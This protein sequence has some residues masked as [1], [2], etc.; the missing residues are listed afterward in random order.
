MSRTS[1]T[2][3]LPRLLAALCCFVV[4][5]Y[6]ALVALDA[7]IYRLLPR[8]RLF[9]PKQR[10]LLYSYGVFDPATNPLY[11]PWLHG[12]VNK[13][14]LPPLPGT[15][16]DAYRAYGMYLP[17]PPT[18]TVSA[19]DALGWWNTRMPRDA[20]VLF[21]G[22]SFCYGA[23]SGSA[24]SIPALYEKATGRP[25]YA[26]CKNG[27]GLPQYRDILR[28][29]TEEVPADSPEHFG[30]RTVYVLLYIGNDVAA[31]L[32]VY[33]DRVAEEARG[34]TRHF[35][36]LTLLRLARFLRD[37]E[38]GQGQA[39]AAGPRPAIDTRG[40]YP[41]PLTVPTQ[42][43]LPFASHPFYRTFA[44][45]AWF[46]PAEEKQ[47]RGVLAGLRRI[48]DREHIRL[49][50]ILIPT[51]LQVLYPRIDFN[52]VPPRSEFARKAGDEIRNLNALSGLV[53]LM[54][55]DTGIETLDLMPPLMDAPDAGLL[56]WPTDSHLTP[57][58]NAAVV[59]A[60]LRAFPDDA[61]GVCPAKAVA[62]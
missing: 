30:G 39:L 15:A 36:L 42:K 12:Y 60:M 41:V 43:G 46:G 8:T 56:Y 2:R 35:E 18:L 44:D 1:R 10:E 40:Y 61:P 58:G 9:S 53:S 47:V 28:H 29:L 20:S 14:G 4:V 52:A 5:L 32:F 49:G 48:A 11:R 45:T 33:R 51:A 54:L 62:P 34:A 3:R 24:A 37:A 16:D 6:L 21:I 7:G 26:A 17:D 22:D 25:V 13:P 55:Q 50:V 23:G 31:D 57:R 38:S 27:Y 59:A 19:T